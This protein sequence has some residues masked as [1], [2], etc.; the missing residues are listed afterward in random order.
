MSALQG[1]ITTTFFFRKIL[2]IES[3]IPWFSSRVSL[4]VFFGLKLSIQANRGRGWDATVEFMLN[5]ELGYRSR[6]LVFYLFPATLG[7]DP[8]IFKKNDAVG[9]REELG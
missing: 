7:F 9:S 6:G 1:C 8:A 5:A 3:Q 2:T 4:C